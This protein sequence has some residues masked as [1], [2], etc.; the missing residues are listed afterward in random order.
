M[1]GLLGIGYAVIAAELGWMLILA[2]Q[3]NVLCGRRADLLWLAR[4]A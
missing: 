2:Y 1:P 4:H 3:A